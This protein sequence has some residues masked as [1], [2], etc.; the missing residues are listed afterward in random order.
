MSAYETDVLDRLLQRRGVTVPAPVAPPPSSDGGGGGGSPP[1]GPQLHDVQ[2]EPAKAPPQPTVVLPWREREGN[3]EP[4]NPH[5]PRNTHARTVQG[6]SH[7]HPT[8]LL[9]GHARARVV[10]I[11][12]QQVAH[13]LDEGARP[14]G[15]A[16]EP[17]KAPIEAKQPAVRRTT[18]P[19]GLH[20]IERFEGFRARPY[21]DRAGNATIGYGHLLH[22]GPVT[23]EDVRRWGVITPSEGT[24][25][26][27]GDIATAVKAVHEVVHVP[28][29]QSQ[30]D[31]LVSFTFNVGGHGLAIS[32]ALK[33]LNAGHYG[34][35]P[36]DLL[37]F[38]RGVPGL[39][40]RHRTEGLMFS[41][42]IYPK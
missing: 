12:P 4:Y 35:V 40:S 26:L 5:R 34:R 16:D 28:L 29:T 33:D 24:K 39:Q 17:P 25:L 13:G 1:S 6:A 23:A 20:A 36:G 14:A 30:F 38:D 2:P 3:A 18:S 21:N 9:Q 42:G 19:R 11:T 8:A 10:P 27:H 32:D 15:G 22:H 7:A 37:H 41:R 31:A